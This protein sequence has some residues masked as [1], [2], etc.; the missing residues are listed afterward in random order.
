MLNCD[1]IK[2]GNYN[3]HFGLC[4]SGFAMEIILMY[5]YIYNIGDIILLIDNLYITLF[6]VVSST[7]SDILKYKAFM[8]LSEY[9]F[10][11]SLCKYQ[12][13]R[14]FLKLLLLP[15]LLSTNGMPSLYLLNNR[16]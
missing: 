7:T 16:I 13:L 4:S 3:L 8:S 9:L 11:L 1:F 6:A 10:C 14:P 5:V 15:K 2:A 12:Q